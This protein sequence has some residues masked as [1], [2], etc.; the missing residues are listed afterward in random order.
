MTQAFIP[1]MRR[2]GIAELVAS[3]I[4]NISSVG[5]KLSGWTQEQSMQ[6]AFKTSSTQEQVRELRDGYLSA[7]ADGSES[8]E[9]WPKGK[10]YSVS[11]SLVNASTRVLAAD[12]KD[13]LINC[14]CPGWVQTDMGSMIGQ[15]AK[16]LEEG[17]RVPLNLAFGP[18]SE[19]GQYW[20]NPSVAD[21][22]K[23]QVSDW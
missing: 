10:S 16:T 9:G 5:S 13:L 6:Q 22:G 20:E 14:C 19:T 3:R 17:T 2:P 15:P 18:I 23:G 8:R 21:T 7:V 11:K 4:V 12:N 1:L